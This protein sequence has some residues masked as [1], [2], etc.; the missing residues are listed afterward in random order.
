[1]KNLR[2]I[3]SV[4]CTLCL[5]GTFSVKAQK[6]IAELTL[7]YEYSVSSVSAGAKQTD[8][9]ANAT[10]TIYIKGSKSRSEMSNS[11]FSS[12]TLFDASTGSG[13]ILREV[14]GQKLLI[15]LTAEN[16]QERNRLYEGMVFKTTSSETRDIAGYKCQQ[17]TAQTKNGAT[18]T[19][20]YTRDVIPDNKD[21]DPIFKNLDGLPLEYELTN[22]D[23]KI[24]YKVSK[25][26]FNPVPASKFDL[27]KSGYREMNYEDSK[28]VN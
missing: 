26:N 23:M 19:V 27:P 3:L 28:K 5:F 20:F 7:V 25:I 21:Y 9:G 17:A 13:V 15:N 8:A 12:T 1:M 22:G 10:H 24:R 18:L 6:K 4:I 16:W 14:S 2:S 11:L